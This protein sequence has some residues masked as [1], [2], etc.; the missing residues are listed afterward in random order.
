MFTGH[1]EPTTMNVYWSKAIFSFSDRTSGPVGSSLPIVWG[2]VSTVLAPRCKQSSGCETGCVQPF[3]YKQ[4][5]F[6]RAW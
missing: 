6:D 2:C 4:E 5:C 3:H 1:G